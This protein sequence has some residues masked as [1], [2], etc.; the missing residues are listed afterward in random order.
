MLRY[1][2]KCRDCDEVFEKMY[3]GVEDENGWR[4]AVF[5]DIP[6]VEDC[7][8]GGTSD[9]M[10]PITI[11]IIVD[12]W[13]PETMDAQRDIDH[14]NKPIIVN[15]KYRSRKTMYYHDQQMNNPFPETKPFGD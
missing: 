1:D 11:G 13:T 7:K 14:F 4:S 10:F 2:F 3:Q 9:R 5:S 8:C 15:G 12:D 6:E